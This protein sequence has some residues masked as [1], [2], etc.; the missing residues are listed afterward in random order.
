MCFHT[1][2]KEA[3][4]DLDS[5]TIADTTSARFLGLHLE[6]DLSWAEQIAKALR[7]GS[8]ALRNF[9]HFLRN[10]RLNVDVKL[11]IIKTY[12]VPAMQFGMEVWF[13]R[14][15]EEKQGG[16]HLGDVL[17]DA[18]EESLSMARSHP[19]C[20]SRHN[21]QV[22]F[23]SVILAFLACA[24]KANLHVFACSIAKLPLC[25]NCKAPPLL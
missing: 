23:S 17:V 15:P 9:R 25:P 21:L 13:P 24:Q 6:P 10:P 11:L 19:K 18:V 7:N 14:F 8:N 16:A 4:S 3:A 5:Q 2:G 22:R 12:I 20:Y 1:C